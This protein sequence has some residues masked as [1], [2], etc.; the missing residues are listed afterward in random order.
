[1]TSD[2]KQKV[3]DPTS[4]NHPVEGEW[5]RP[6]KKLATADIP[7]QAINT[8][9]AGMQL[10]G[11][12]TGFGQLWRKTYRVRLEGAAV[13]PEEVVARWKVKYP[14]YWPKSGRFYAPK[15]KIEPGEVA[16]IN[17]SGPGGLPIST[18]VMVIYSDD[19]SFAFMTPQGHPFSGIITYGSEA[20][21]ETTA[22]Q[23]QV[24]VRASDPIFEMSARMGIAHKSED[25]FW[26]A[27][28]LNLAVD[29]GVSGQS[30]VRTDELMDDKVQWGKLGNVWHNSAIRT[31]IYLPVHAVKRL[32]GK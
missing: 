1:M 24:L 31:T 11:P 23:I 21:G 27:T 12:T 4:P 30:V 25:A 32:T 26:E 19:E 2:T 5:A 10:A 7:P 29:W 16:V 3:H 8:N 13:T 9:V 14:T 20:D 28:L 15:A 22:A 17:L 6:V 18:G